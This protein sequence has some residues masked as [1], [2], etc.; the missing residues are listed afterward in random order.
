VAWL[1]GRS[2]GDGAPADL[3][4]QAHG[5]EHTATFVP[6]HFPCEAF[7]FQQCRVNAA[8]PN[9]GIPLDRPAAVG[10]LVNRPALLLA[11]VAEPPFVLMNPRPPGSAIDHSWVIVVFSGRAPAFAAGSRSHILRSTCPAIRAACDPCDSRSEKHDQ[12]RP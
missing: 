9:C 4:V 5:D 2:A 10:P 3:P 1:A 11:H 8:W 7:R 12:K 6:E